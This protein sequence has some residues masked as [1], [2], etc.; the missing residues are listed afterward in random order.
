MVLATTGG[1]V[2][3]HIYDEEYW[4]RVFP[5]AHL[6]VLAVVVAVVYA[7]HRVDLWWFVRS[8]ERKGRRW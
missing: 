4:E 5:W 8:E 6:L 3:H 2:N 1:E 7:I